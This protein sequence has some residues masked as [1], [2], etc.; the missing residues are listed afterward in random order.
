MGIG[1]LSGKPDDI[2]GGGGW[3]VTLQWTSIPWWGEVVILLVAYAME[4]RMTS[5]WV[6]HLARVQTFPFFRCGWSVPF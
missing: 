6:G 1:E 3:G 5:D 4:I 2:R